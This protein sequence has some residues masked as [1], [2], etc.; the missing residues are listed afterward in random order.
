M[1]SGK[2]MS[3]PAVNQSMQALLHIYE[4]DVLIGVPR[5]MCFLAWR[6]VSLLGQAKSCRGVCL[7]ARR[8]TADRRFATATQ[9]LDAAPVHSR[10]LFA[11]TSSKSTI[12]EQS[13]NHSA[14]SRV[15]DVQDICH[16]V[17]TG[18]PA[19]FGHFWVKLL[20]LFQQ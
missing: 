17:S 3:E 10:K 19:G 7:T 15:I 1:R 18:Q 8:P 13:R 2:L 11:G 12:S 5:L 16:L 20:E 14:G 9:A 6:T 4:I